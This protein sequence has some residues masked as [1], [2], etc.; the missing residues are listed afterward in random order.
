MDPDRTWERVGNGRHLVGSPHIEDDGGVPPVHPS[1]ELIGTDSRRP[2]RPQQAVPAGPPDRQI[3]N[4]CRHAEAKEGH[5][6]IRRDLG[7]CT[8][9]E[10]SKGH[11][12]AGPRQGAP[13]A[14]A[15]ATAG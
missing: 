12:S 13:W 14:V 2:E 11:P 6:E 3:E 10:V 9:E 15:D 8:V 7:P 5:L 1:L 4:E